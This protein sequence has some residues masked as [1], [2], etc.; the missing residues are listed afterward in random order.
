MLAVWLLR[1]DPYCCRV[2]FSEVPYM[3]SKVDSISGRGCSDMI[4]S[5]GVAVM[6]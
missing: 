5:V 1:F 6:I 2:M 3:L 4:L